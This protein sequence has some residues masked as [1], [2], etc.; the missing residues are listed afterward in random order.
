MKEKY[1]KLL[2]VTMSCILL[3]VSGCAPQ[4]YTPP[5]NTITANRID[6]TLYG[7]DI[8]RVNVLPEELDYA[9]FYLE[10]EENEFG[11]GLLMKFEI[12]SHQA[13]YLV[14][15][16]TECLDEK[17]KV[18]YMELPPSTTMTTLYVTTENYY[19]ISALYEENQLVSKGIFDLRELNNKEVPLVY[20][21]GANSGITIIGY[22]EPMLNYH[23]ISTI[24]FLVAHKMTDD[25]LEPAGKMKLT[26]SLEEK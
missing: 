7:N 10:N 24:E 5:K 22:K 12:G 8:K 23:I 25:I 26:L 16:E 3:F 19:F 1:R 18:D 14:K 2:M 6:N 4:S 9:T 11:A 13:D 17:S 15:L 21:E 20:T